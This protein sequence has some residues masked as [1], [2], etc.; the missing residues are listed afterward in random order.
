[1]IKSLWKKYVNSRDEK[2]LAEVTARD[3]ELGIPTKETLNDRMTKAADKGQWKTAFDAID[4]GAD[5]DARVKLEYSIVS[6]TQGG[7]YRFKSDLTIAYDAVKQDNTEALFKLLAKGADRFA[8]GFTSVNGQRRDYTLI[9]YA[10]HNG[11]KGSAGFLLGLD[12]K[13]PQD[14]L[15]RALALA[16]REKSY[17]VMVEQLLKAGAQGFDA[18]LRSAELGNNK[19]AI[20]MIRTAQ[21]AASVTAP[22]SANDN[23]AYERIEQILKQV[24]PA[25]RP[26]I[27]DTLSRKFGEAQQPETA[28]PATPTP[29]LAP[30]PAPATPK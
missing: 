26:G 14:A 5:I 3:A 17:N 19:G 21:A 22:S 25:L 28:T 9:E 4:K 16:A 20:K 23:D 7:G 8:T 30:A 11:A 10:V 27:V 6:N 29:T 13:P 1:M 18:A 12:T 2:Q 24:P 15:D